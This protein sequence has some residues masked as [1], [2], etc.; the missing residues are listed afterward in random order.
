MKYVVAG[1]TETFDKYVKAHPQIMQHV[2]SAA[3]VSALTK[4]DTVVFLPGWF[5][6]KWTKNLIELINTF[7]PDTTIEYLDGKIGK[8]ER[9]NLQSES[10]NS[11]FDILDL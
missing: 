5:A 10:I 9:N 3:F 2:K 1:K 4:D 6:K 7:H 8:K 11:R